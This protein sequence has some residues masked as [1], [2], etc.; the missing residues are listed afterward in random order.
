MR[1]D[2]NNFAPRVSLSW[3]PFGDHKTVVRAG[4]GMFYAP[5]YFQIDA[6]V[7]YLGV[8]NRMNGNRQVT[9]LSTCASGTD[10]FRQIAQVF[11]QLNCVPASPPSLHSALIFQTLF[12]QGKITCGTPAAGS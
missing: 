1:T 12:A 8:I 10:C 3:D 6:A 9:D 11:V 2:G 7:N 4:Y 5:I